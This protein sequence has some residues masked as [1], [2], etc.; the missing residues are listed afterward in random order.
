MSKLIQ[1]N[2]QSKSSK[3]SSKNSKRTYNPVN[4]EHYKKYGKQVWEMMV[5]IWGTDLYIAFCEMN[6]FKY[7]MRAGDK[8]EADIQKDLEKAKW[9][10]NL[11]KQLRDEGKKSNNLSNHL[12]HTGGRSHDVRYSSNED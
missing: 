11:A 9:Y 5:D 6:S 4:P 7:R 8:P 2:A 10:E 3:D 1:S 12:S